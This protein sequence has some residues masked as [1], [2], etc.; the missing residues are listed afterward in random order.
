MCL[1]AL[2]GAKCHPSCD[3]NMG[4]WGP[5]RQDCI[6]CRSHSIDNSICVSS[7]TELPGFYEAQTESN[8][9]L[10]TLPPLGNP[11]TKRLQL[12]RLAAGHIIQE[13]THSRYGISDQNSKA[14]IVCSRC[15]PECAETCKGPGSDQCV[16]TCK[17]ARVSL[18]LGNPQS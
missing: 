9:M 18:I 12:A 17:N 10:P 8:L 3:H 7:C 2:R 4:C 16:G 14:S 15:H 11:L 1:E 13:T 6:R 5:R